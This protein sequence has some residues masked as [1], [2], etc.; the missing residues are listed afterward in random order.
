VSRRTSFGQAGTDLMSFSP[1]P[2]HSPTSPTS[3]LSPPASPTFSDTHRS[4]SRERLW[5]DRRANRA[6]SPASPVISPPPSPRQHTYPR[7]DSI[8]F[9][10][11][12]SGHDG[13]EKGGE[14]GVRR[15]RGIFGFFRRS[16][17]SSLPPSVE[18]V[19]WRGPVSST[20]I[21]RPPSGPVSVRHAQVDRTSNGSVLDPFR[22]LS[23]SSF[24]ISQ[25]GAE[26][27]DGM[28]A[29]STTRSSMVVEDREMLQGLPE[30]R[31]R[32]INSDSTASLGDHTDYS[33][34][35]GG[36]RFS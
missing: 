13:P 23:S 16:R 14:S 34:P 28:P 32:V 5:V 30:F 3:L 7:P 4:G 26:E 15:L 25:F 8:P 11:T 36:V 33:P 19:P 20:M 6:H 2:P 18:N 22:E 1:S 31:M 35:I 12:P 27:E 10:I 29:P 21:Q 24:A 9:L 17:T